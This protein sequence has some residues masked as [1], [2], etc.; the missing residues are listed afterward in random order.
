MNRKE[1]RT[2]LA[3][4]RDAMDKMSR[5]ELDDFR[6]FRERDKDDEDLDLISQRRLEQLHTK[7]AVKKSPK[8][9]DALLKK[10]SRQVDDFGPD[11]SD[12]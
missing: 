7:Y 4:L 5:E 1:Q 2:L 12:C 11:R 9:I 8:D 10:Y 6:M 3:E